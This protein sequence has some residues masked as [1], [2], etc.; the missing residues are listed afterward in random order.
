VRVLSE[1]G[2]KVIPADLPDIDITDKDR[3]QNLIVKENPDA[4]IHLAAY[5]AVDKA[6]EERDLCYDINVHGT[7]YIA[8]VCGK[9]SIPVL[10]TSTD[11]VF[12]GRGTDPYEI[13]SP[14]GPENQYGF[15]KLMG[16]KEIRK[17]CSKYFIVRISWVFGING[18]N[19]VNTIIE[20]S[21]IRDSLDVVC[22]QVG[23]PTYTADLAFLLKNMI[24]SDKYGIYHATNEGFCSWSDFA[25][26]II[27][28]TGA[29][30]FINPVLSSEYKTAAVRP[31][32]SR[33]SKDSLDRAGFDRL[34][35]WHDALRNY[36]ILK[37]V[38]ND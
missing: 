28:L 38:I 10:Y 37:G 13:D 7:S 36:L 33:L 22:D 8:E 25:E 31:H 35:D 11:Y 17:Y 3:I 9:L 1:A 15:T 30:T 24:E 2:H 26:E 23:S 20:L 4:V 12:N 6:E 19:F 27:N 32:N 14:V 18:K 34:P 5:V 16:E 29:D 21:S